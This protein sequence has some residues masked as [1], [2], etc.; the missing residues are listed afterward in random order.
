[1]KL[2][3]STIGLLLASALLFSLQ[4][5]SEKKQEAAQQEVRGLRG[6]K[7]SAHA[8]SRIRR[9]PSILQPA[10]VSPLSFEIAGQLKAITLEVGQKVQL[11]D[12]LAEIEPKSLQAQ[13]V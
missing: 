11:G 5:C 12:L 7:V 6:Y 13:V 3:Q 9:F 4:N 8:Q 2:D 10:D 1:M